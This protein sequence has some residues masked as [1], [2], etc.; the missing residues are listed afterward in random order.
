M[1]HLFKA[2]QQNIVMQIPNDAQQ[3]LSVLE[4]AGYQAY[5]VGG[6]VRDTILGKVPGDW[7]ITTSALPMQVKS[8]FKRTIDTGIKHGTV[9]VM[10][11]QVGYEVTTYR[12]DGDYADGRHPDSVEFSVSLRDDLKRRDFTINAM[13]YNPSTGLVDE[14]NGI[15]DLE[16]GIIRCVGNATE[17]FTE[18]ALR[19]MRAIRF[20]AQ[21]GF[22]IE[23]DTY[24]AIMRMSANI[25]KVSMERIHDELGKTLM[26]DN[27]DYVRL[28]SDTGLTTDILPVIH[29]LLTDKKAPSTLRLL[30]VSEK[31]PI[32]RYAALLNNA[33]A[34]EA[35]DTLR[36]LK[37]DNNTISTVTKLVKLSKTGIDESE[38][39][40][41]EAIH[42]YG[43]EFV[44]MLIKHQSAVLTE[45]EQATGIQMMAA[46]KHL[47]IIS[48]MYNEIIER[49]DCISIKDLD[50]SGNDLMEIGFSGPRIGETLNKLLYFVM[51][52][53]ELNDKQ[54]LLAMI[55][56]V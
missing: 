15:D 42:L 34:E 44:P 41:R 40:V 39:A 56:V 13:A 17:R 37:L 50:I 18:D 7:D 32:L 38:P 45:K 43:K 4:S 46:R 23:H 5:V 2:D 53:P 36:S 8:L 12:I 1:E 49:G 10:M 47:A 24:V 26:S 21:L 51:E 48:R 6:C 28:L 14:F 3:I 27:P 52:N 22:E 19:M 31:N 20:S 30:K 54:T 55:D 29:N 25:G 35:N 33:S 16:N 11:N 9:T